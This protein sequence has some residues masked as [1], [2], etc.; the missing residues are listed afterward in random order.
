[1]QKYNPLRRMALGELD[2]HLHRTGGVDRIQIGEQSPAERHHRDEVLVQVAELFLGAGGVEPITVTATVRRTQRQCGIQ[3]QHPNSVLRSP[4]RQFLASD[5]WQSW[6][7]R[8]VASAARRKPQR[9]RPASPILDAYRK[10]CRN[11][12]AA[13]VGIASLVRPAAR[14]ARARCEKCQRTQRCHSSIGC[15]K[16]NIHPAT[17]LEPGASGTCNDTGG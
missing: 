11:T 17:M 13:D 9:Y 8:A 7:G 1:M 6:H 15:D 2:A 12:R 5:P 3:Q 10:Q 16:R 4:R 14:S